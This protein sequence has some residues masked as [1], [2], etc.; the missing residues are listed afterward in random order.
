EALRSRQVEGVVVIPNGLEADLLAGKDVAVTLRFDRSRTEADFAERKLNKVLAGY[1][2]WVVAQRLKQYGA[3]PTVTKGV[4]RNVEDV[5]TATQRMG[6][7]LAQMMPMLVLIT[8]MLGA[9]FPALS[10]T[11]TERE[12]GT[13][14]TLLVSPAGRG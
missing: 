10:A 7:R 4:T 14:E 9:L 12:L 13:L 5:S 1:Q 3:P 8:G 6:N 2:E 11:T